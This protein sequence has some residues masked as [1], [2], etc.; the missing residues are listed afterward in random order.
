[1]LFSESA[2][3]I[4]AAVGPSIL[5]IHHVGSTSVPGLCAKPILDILISIPDF[6]EAL[7]LVPRIEALGYEFRPNEGVA[8]R[9]FFRRPYGG[10]LRT[11]HLSLSEPSSRDHTRVIVFR[12]ALRND[13]TLAEEYGRLKMRLAA[14]H[15][16]DRPA[17]IEAKDVFIDRVLAASRGIR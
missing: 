3:E 10:E 17:Y 2:K 6:T 16:H 8:D 12:D 14:I 4:E 15:P 5:G 11:H 1:L 7:S 13:P 9:H